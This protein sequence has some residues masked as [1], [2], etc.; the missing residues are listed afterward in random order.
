MADP[1]RLPALPAPLALPSAELQQEAESFRLPGEAT[2][3]W[4]RHDSVMVQHISI[5]PE[6]ANARVK[7]AEASERPY[8]E[9]TKQV[10]ILGIVAT[11][12]IVFGLIAVLYSPDADRA[13]AAVALVAVLGT[14]FAG[15]FGVQKLID[16]KKPPPPG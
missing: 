15:V 3:S 13:K 2:L 8:V 6:L 9:R 11:V 1:R 16:R 7:E 5:S 4:T 14:L 10:L 12:T